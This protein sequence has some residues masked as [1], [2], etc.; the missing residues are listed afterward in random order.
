MPRNPYLCLVIVSCIGLVAALG[1]LGLIVE[2]ILT[3]SASPAVVAI[4]STCVGSL[5]SFLVQV[6]ARSVGHPGEKEEKA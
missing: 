2:D 3:H 6:P 4:V 5:A 1:M